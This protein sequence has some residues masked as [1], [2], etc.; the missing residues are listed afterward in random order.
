MG[1]KNHLQGKKNWADPLGEPVAERDSYLYW[2]EFQSGSQAANQ[3][4]FLNGESFS[5][6]SVSHG[7]PPSFLIRT[8]LGTPHEEVVELKPEGDP[9]RQQYEGMLLVPSLMST[10][11]QAKQIPKKLKQKTELLKKPVTSHKRAGEHGIIHRWV[12]EEVRLSMSKMSI[13][14]LVLG[15]LFL[16]TLFF[17]IGF[18]AAVATLKTDEGGHHSQSAWQASNAPLQGEQSHGSQG[19]GGQLGRMV[20]A[21]GGSLVGNAVRKQ[22][23]PVQKV[24][25]ATTAIVPRPLQPFARYGTNTAHA[26]VQSASNQVNPFRGMPIATQQPHAG[27]QQPPEAPQQYAPP[28]AQAYASPPNFPP[29]SGYQQPTAVPQGGQGGYAQAYVPQQQQMMMPQQ[30]PPQQQPYYQQPLQQ[31]PL[32]QQ[33]RAPQSMM[34]PQMAPQM[35]PQPQ[36]VPPQQQMMMQPQQ[37]Q[38]PMVPYQQ[39]MA[40]QQGYYR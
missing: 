29:A 26:H 6:S 3:S 22:L 24:A 18:L 36:M 11:E 16:G 34:V 14:S 10:S 5:H 27:V 19:G 23:A 9:A 7:P 8:P 38:Q 12:Y 17:I 13:M 20:G 32:Q 28:Q 37:Y 2:K 1:L 21:V 40:P 4:S 15:L 30:M 39:L 31:Q 25:G 35:V 33:P